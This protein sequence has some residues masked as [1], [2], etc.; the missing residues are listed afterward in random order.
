MV[1]NDWIEENNKEEFFQKIKD[2]II[3]SKN[4][5]NTITTN[6]VYTTLSFIETEV[7][8]MKNIWTL[9]ETGNTDILS[10]KERFINYCKTAN[11]GSELTWELL[12]DS[13][14]IVTDINGGIWRTVSP[15]GNILNVSKDG[16][17]VSNI[18]KQDIID[19]VYE[20]YFQYIKQEESSSSNENLSIS[21]NFDLMGSIVTSYELTRKSFRENYFRE[22]KGFEEIPN[23]WEN[24][25]VIKELNDLITLCYAIFK[26][27]F[28]DTEEKNS[29][30]TLFSYGI[31]SIL[32]N[33]KDKYR[34]QLLSTLDD[35]LETV[36]DTDTELEETLE[37]KTIGIISLAINY[38]TII[39]NNYETFKQSFSIDMATSLG[40]GVN[41]VEVLSVE[42]GSAVVIF[43]LKAPEAEKLINDLKY[44]AIP[45]P[46]F[47]NIRG[48]TG[49]N[50]IMVNSIN[51]QTI[52]QQDDL[53]DLNTAIDNNQNLLETYNNIETN[54]FKKDCC[55]E[56]EISKSVVVCKVPN[57][58]NKVYN[59]TPRPFA[60]VCNGYPV[61]KN[62]TETNEWFAS[63]EPRIQR[64][65][66][67]NTITNTKQ[68][69]IISRGF[70][71]GSWRDLTDKEE[72]KAYKFTVPTKQSKNLFKNTSYNMSRRELIAY[73][74]R[75]H[76]IR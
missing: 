6:N 53:K 75:N 44:G 24:Q 63:R 73:L 33:F 8:N 42:A 45:P 9:F 51:G 19:M 74:S 62:E 41:S 47:L 32:V 17:E 21:I 23:V 56:E 3:E 4:L 1:M 64:G 14:S 58:Y 7:V 2:Q 16:I 46:Q 48:L 61:F 43:V 13:D 67:N 70:V 29:I 66:W 31:S 35:V 71:Y 72:D 69:P 52:T 20:L 27:N 34:E 55:V 54:T 76:V 40:V 39:G 25:Q 5:F 60:N 30:I 50:S 28:N 57:V 11:N 68:Y 26:S 49:L 10:V 12:N 15:T 59:Q 18:T 65:R 22:Y 37:P 38:N 36:E